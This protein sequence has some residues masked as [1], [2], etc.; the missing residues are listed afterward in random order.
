MTITI[1]AEQRDALY[2]QVLVRLGREED[3]LL[4]AGKGDFAG[5]DRLA[6]ELA[7]N[8]RLLLND[9]RW[10]RSP[11]DRAIALSSPS[12]LLRRFF[13]RHLELA[14]KRSSSEAQ[15]RAELREAEEQNR[16]VIDV[17]A[18]GLAALDAE[19]APATEDADAE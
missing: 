1:E 8:L 10:G 14:A 7:D 9:L 11:F 13:T 15:E 2:E 5:A 19:P 6:Q 4:L 12:D 17:C 18:A 3:V 16:L